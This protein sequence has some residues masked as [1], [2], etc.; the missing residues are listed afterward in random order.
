V[1]WGDLADLGRLV[2]AGVLGV[3][4]VVAMIRGRGRRL[5]PQESRQE[6]ERFRRS[7]RSRTRFQ[8][9][10]LLFAAAFAVVLAAWRRDVALAGTALLLAAGAGLL[11]AVQAGLR[12]G[13]DSGRS[14]RAE[15]D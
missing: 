15:P 1:P 4:A 5:S 11:A 8:I 10:L 3:I 14:E 7:A 12:G 2:L 6:V 9:G 13:A